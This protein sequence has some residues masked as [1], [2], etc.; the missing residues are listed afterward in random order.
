[1]ATPKKPGGRQPSP[2]E[3]MNALDRGNVDQHIKDWV[4][5]IIAGAVA[6]VWPADDNTGNTGSNGV[7]DDTGDV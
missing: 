1:M 3:I 4:W 2:E 6:A 7:D 5:W